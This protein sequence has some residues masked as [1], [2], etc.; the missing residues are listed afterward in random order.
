MKEECMDNRDKRSPLIVPA[1]NRE[2]L[3]CLV[4]LAALF[5]LFASKMG[6]SHM[7]GTMMSTAYSIIIDTVLFIMAVAVVTGAFS[8]LLTE[9]GVLALIN[10]LLSPLMKPIYGLPGAASLGVVST[11]LS[12]SPAMIS[13]GQDPGF[14]K[15]FTKRQRALITNLGTTFGMGL[16]VC[17]FMLGVSTNN[18]MI[19]AVFCGLMASVV[20]SVISVR[21]MDVFAKRYFKNSESMCV[22]PKKEEYDIMTERKIRPGSTG[23]RIMGA[24]LDGGQTGVTMGL[25]I[26]APN[27]IICTFVMMLVRVPP[28]GEFTGGAMEGI[29]LIPLIANKLD[30]IISPLFGFSSPEAIAFPC[31]AVGSVG[32]SLGMVKEFLSAGLIGANDI[33]VF[34]AM[35]MT[36]SGYLS[37]HVAMMDALDSRDL[38]GKAILSHTIA[39]LCAG[40]MAHWI[41]V[42]VSTHIVSI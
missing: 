4:G 15:Y 31:T 23:S 6:V 25:G 26:V 10:K 29:G 7:F 12:D 24:L 20:A 1:V 34:T 2:T 42:L 33:A 32:A 28:G 35:G 17:T 22:D 37:V 38:A 14:I 30:F 19:A 11:F 36:Y 21:L 41:Y 18:H 27:V 3:Y 9:F 16:I 40:I 39:G 8:G 5:T 13:L